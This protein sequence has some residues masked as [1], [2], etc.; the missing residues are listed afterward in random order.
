MEARRF[1]ATAKEPPPR[2]PPAVY[3][4][5]PHTDLT[6]QLGRRKTD[7]GKNRRIFPKK[8]SNI[9]IERKI[10]GSQ[11][12]GDRIQESEVGR[13]RSKRKVESG[14]FTGGIAQHGSEGNEAFQSGKLKFES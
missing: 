4:I 13:R 6:T 9:P 3:G 12:T 10:E 14:N 7:R 2:L 1:L 5:H 8:R 11:E